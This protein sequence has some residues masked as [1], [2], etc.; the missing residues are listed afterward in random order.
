MGIIGTL[1]NQIIVLSDF[2]ISEKLS[3]IT[4]AGLLIVIKCI[5]FPVLDKLR[6]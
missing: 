5:I 2:L 1:S 3:R 6:D 4:H